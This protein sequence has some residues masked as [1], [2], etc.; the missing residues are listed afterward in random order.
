VKSL[1]KKKASR[2]KTKPPPEKLSYEQFEEESKAA[3]QKNLDYWHQRLAESRARRVEFQ[4]KKTRQ[5]RT[6]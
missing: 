4:K 5:S 1:V 3:A 6:T 2:R